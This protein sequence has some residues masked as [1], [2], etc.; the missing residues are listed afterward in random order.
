MTPPDETPSLVAAFARM[1]ADATID[2]LPDDVVSSVPQR[3]LDIVGIAV[4]AASLDTSVSAT[5]WAVEQAGT[6][7][8]TAIGVAPLLPAPAAAFVNGVLAHSLDYDDTHLPSILHPSASVVPAALAAAQRHDATGPQVVAAIAAGLEIAVR[9]GMVGFDRSTRRNLW[10]DRGLHATSIC[11]TIGSAAA[12]ARLGGLGAEGVA[13][14]M[15]VAAS[16]ASGII[17]ANRTGGTVKRLHCGWAAHAGVSAA[18]LATHGLTGP[19][20]V[21]EGRF[22]LFEAL[23]GG[24]MFLDE[25][26]CELGERWSVA[27]INYKP[28]PANHYTHCAADAAI[29]LRRRHGVTP[30]QID[31]VELRVASATVRTIG[32][33]ID[34]KR[35]PTTAYQCQFS[36]PYVVAAALLGGSGLGLGLADFTDELAVEP[37]R[38]QLMAKVA[39][40]GDAECDRIY[41]D[42]FPAVLTVTLVDGTELVERVLTNR[43]GVDRPLTVVELAQKFRDNVGDILST[44][45]ADAI[46]AACAALTRDGA[47][48]ADVLAPTRG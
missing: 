11:G 23:L 31:H 33:P 37:I 21:F 35:A 2:S 38:R 1:A 29:A 43:G 15:G 36:G 30:E 32:E 20:T 16:M 12:A 41:P 46:V 14:A 6:E 34:S 10:F 47:T 39:V 25:A 3:I 19:P 17:E 26:W 24:E 44:S 9:L 42:Q 22:G 40:V 45:S 28:Y 27:D 48:A 18:G 5:Q 13:H 8:S 7:Q 4:R